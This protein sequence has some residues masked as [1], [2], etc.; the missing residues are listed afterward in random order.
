MMRKQEIGREIL[1]QLSDWE[2]AADEA[3]LHVAVEDRCGRLL[4]SEFLA[5]LR[6]CEE[7]GWITGVW[8]ELRGVRWMITD[9]GRMV[10][11]A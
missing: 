1:R 3:V 4:V 11:R 2:D 5:A 8:N 7:R 10:R 9:K 6:L